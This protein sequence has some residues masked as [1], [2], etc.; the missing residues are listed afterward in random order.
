MLLQAW[1]CVEYIG[2][3]EIG[4][5]AQFFPFVLLS[6]L[7]QVEQTGQNREMMMQKEL[8]FLL[9]GDT[10]G[11]IEVQLGKHRK[12]LMFYYVLTTFL[13]HIWVHICFFIFCIYKRSLLFV[14]YS[15]TL[16]CLY[17][18][19]DFDLEFVFVIMP[20]SPC[21]ILNVSLTLSSSLCHVTM[22]NHHD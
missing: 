2:L 15:F 1:A 10:G 16:T 12:I 11:T 6:L 21:H 3:I 8:G 19:K 9:K 18:E 17:I 4:G 13:F 22:S 7:R 5:E 14:P 20:D